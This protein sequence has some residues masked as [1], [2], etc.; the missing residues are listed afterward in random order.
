MDRVE[1]S[2]PP[3]H[4]HPNRTDKKGLERGLE[5][6]SC[7]IAQTVNGALTSGYLANKSSGFQ[8]YL[9]GQNGGKSKLWRMLAE[10]TPE[11]LALCRELKDRPRNSSG[12][13]LLAA[14][15][16]LKYRCRNIFTA[17]YTV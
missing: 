8:M 10:G 7:A 3:E 13:L 1:L 15:S 12:G 4:L 17:A 5:A 16:P 9:I 14:A 6:S 2:P 11:P